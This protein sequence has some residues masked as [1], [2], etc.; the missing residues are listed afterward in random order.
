MMKANDGLKPVS[1]V[2]VSGERCPV[3]LPLDS[4][5]KVRRRNRV[6]LLVN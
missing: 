1:F 3:S 4:K 5:E 2:M 6:K